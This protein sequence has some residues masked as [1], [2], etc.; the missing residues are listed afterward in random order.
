MKKVFFFVLAPL[1]LMLM[2]SACNSKSSVGS[3]QPADNR[4]HLVF[5]SPLIDNPVW[6]AAKDG[7][8]E[9]AKEFDFRGDWVGPSAIDV[10]EMTKQI[11]IAIA[12]KADGII[13]QGTGP[14]SM[15]SVLE[16][17]YEAGIP[18]VVVNSD[19]PGAHRLAY[20]GTDPKKIG[21]L[22]AE[23]ILKK[24]RLSKRHT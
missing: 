5:V 21:N 24:I 14:E 20:V 16:M 22:G 12:E 6:Q 9:A 18:V 17:A 13:T 2:A 4:L 11:K 19:I 15:A 1:L 23:A 3:P 8:D 10:D 7:F